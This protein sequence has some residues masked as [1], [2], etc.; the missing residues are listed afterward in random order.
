MSRTLACL[1]AVGVTGGCI[2]DS[3]YSLEVAPLEV[4]RGVTRPLSLT[5]PGTLPAL[6]AFLIDVD[7]PGLVDVHLSAD[8]RRFELHAVGEGQTTVHLVYRDTVLHVPTTVLPAATVS[9]AVRPG[10]I[11]APIGGQVA[12]A[13]IATNT[14]DEQVDVTARTLWTVD[15]PHVARLYSDGT[16]QGMAVGATFLR[17]EL[18]RISQTAAVAVVPAN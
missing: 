13:A 1:L 6:T 3:T 18:D 16:L 10:G 5:T 2:E 9:I 15:D 7:D 12:L 17:A 14:A 8:Q 11:Q 4:P